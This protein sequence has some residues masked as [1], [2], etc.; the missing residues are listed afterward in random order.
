MTLR[1]MFGTEWVEQKSKLTL[2]FLSLYKVIVYCYC[3]KFFL[4]SA[5]LRT[6]S[7]YPPA[8]AHLV[9]SI[10]LPIKVKADLGSPMGRA[11]SL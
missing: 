11:E 1:E 7:Y 6:R 8:K 3:C 9:V 10:A 2:Y 4:L 5:I